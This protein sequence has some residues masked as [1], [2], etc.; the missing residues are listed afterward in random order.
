[1][2]AAVRASTLRQAYFRFALGLLPV[3]VVIW[4]AG[5]GQPLAAVLLF[6]TVLTTMT[7][8]TLVPRCALF[9]RMIKR[10][11]QA[12]NP[13]LLTIDDGPHPEH[14]PAILD[15][16]DRH[17]IKALFYLVGER[18]MQHPELV[19]DILARGHEIGNHTQTHPASTFWMLRP[20]RLWREIAGCQETLAALCPGQPPRFF[21]PP[22]GHHNL[23]TA[24]IAR[25]LGLR[26]MLWTARGFDGVLTDVPT[27]TRR[28]SH[29]LKP[30]AIVLIHEGTPVAVEVAEAVASMMVASGL[31]CVPPASIAFSDDG[32]CEE[33]AC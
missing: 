28:I 15:I 7:I 6:C 30:G 25:S 32:G 18:A 3:P 5:H 13:V 24:L 31:P 1:M 4:L 2:N 21:R 22:A 26:M 14:T 17:R 11:P 20:A 10:L 23:F 8:G 27:I 12:G 19:R 9:G 29:R 16:L 33:G